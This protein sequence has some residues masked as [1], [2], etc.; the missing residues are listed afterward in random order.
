MSF[1]PT[2]RQR[3]LASR[4]LG[5][6]TVMTVMNPDLRLFHGEGRVESEDDS[7]SDEE[8]KVTPSGKLEKELDLVQQTC[9]GQQENNP[10][11]ISRHA[12]RD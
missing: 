3:T 1:T 8:K 2:N 10:V 7:T 12:C 9:V 4:R 6:S 5:V 11:T